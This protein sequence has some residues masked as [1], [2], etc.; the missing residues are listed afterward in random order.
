M[1]VLG[2]GR[3]R[4]AGSRWGGLAGIDDFEDEIG[5]VEFLVGAL[6]ADLFDGVAS[7]AE[8]GGID[9]AEGDT[10]DLDDFLD[11]V[12]GGAGVGADDGALEAEQAIEEAA[13]AYIR[14]TDDDGAC[15]VA[16]DAALFGGVQ[17]AAGA[18]DESGE[19]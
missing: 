4:D 15:T 5:A 3:D 14:L 16:E 12:A 9:E 10:V 2:G 13:F 7:I 17:Q 1:T 19:A 6:D 11:G 8:T 18:V